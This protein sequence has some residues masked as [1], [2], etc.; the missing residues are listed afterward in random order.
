M[1]IG[2][3]YAGFRQGEEWKT[4]PF[5]NI[6]RLGT[7]KYATYVPGNSLLT[8]ISLKYYGNPYMGKL[9]LAAN[10]QLGAD[11]FAIDEEVAL[12]IPFP[13][14]QALEAFEAEVNNYLK[15]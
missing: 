9:I 6:P 3:I 11:E 8:K 14:N 15:T 13:L 4:I 12:R 10:P 7:D 2:N 1:D 5:I